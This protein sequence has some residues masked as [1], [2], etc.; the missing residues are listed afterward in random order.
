MGSFSTSEYIACDKCVI[1]GEYF[2]WYFIYAFLH[3]VSQA[4]NRLFYN[5]ELSY[6][7]TFGNTVPARC[8]STRLLYYAASAAIPRYLDPYSLYAAMRLPW[9]RCGA[10]AI[11]VLDWSLLGRGAALDMLG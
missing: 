9:I 4:E 11:S 5:Y 2:S 6:I 1:L 7:H 8:R 3:K 10:A